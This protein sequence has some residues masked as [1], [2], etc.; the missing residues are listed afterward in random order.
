MPIYYRYKLIG[1]ELIQTADIKPHIQIVFFLP[2]LH[3]S[4]F[5][6]S[7]WYNSIIANKWWDSKFH[8]YKQIYRIILF[9]IL[10]NIN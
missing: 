2:T 8:I 4:L 7:K 1:A 6:M 3:M 10:L 5:F 9:Y